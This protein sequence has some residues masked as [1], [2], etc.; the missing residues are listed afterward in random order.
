MKRKVVQKRLSC[1]TCNYVANIFR[2]MGK[3]KNVG[4]VKHMYCPRCKNTKAF[5]ELQ[6]L[7][8]KA[9]YF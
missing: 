8:K 3:D 5:I 1:T 4:H 9:V 7:T 6:E 2:V